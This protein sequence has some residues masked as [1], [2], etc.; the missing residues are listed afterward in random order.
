MLLKCDK[1]CEKVLKKHTM[2]SSIRACIFINVWTV[3]MYVGWSART[4][5]FGRNVD[6][7]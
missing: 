7:I 4:V 6:N 2:Y 1:I 3:Y 5:T